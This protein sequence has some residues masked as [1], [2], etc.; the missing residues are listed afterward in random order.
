MNLEEI[1]GFCVRL[2]IPGIVETKGGD[3]DIFIP[4]VPLENY[5]RDIFGRSVHSHQSSSVLACEDRC[6]VGPRGSGRRERFSAGGGPGLQRFSPSPWSVFL[7][8]TLIPGS[9]TR[10]GRAT[11]P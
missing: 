4:L 2:S 9:S 5:S 6:L 7:D 11:D 8:S 3:F 1:P 10:A